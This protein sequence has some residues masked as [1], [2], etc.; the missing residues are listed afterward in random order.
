MEREWDYLIHL[1]R[2]AI[3]DIPPEEVPA[4][5]DLQRV[6]ECG[7]YH[8]VANLAF[9]SVER[10]KNPPSDELYN[11]WQSNRDKA[12]VLDFNQ[13]FAADEIRDAFGNENIQWLELQG[14][15]IKPLYPQPEYRTMSDI[16]FIVEKENLLRAGE[17]LESL[18]YSTQLIR[19]Q[20]IVAFREPNI[21]V[22][23]HS[24]YFENSIYNNAMR[25]P[26]K[27]EWDVETFYLYN[28]LHIAKHYRYGGC[29]IR[30]VLDAYMLN[31]AYGEN[32][33]PMQLLEK[34]EDREFAAELLEL[35]NAWFGEGKS[36]RSQMA[37][38]IL[39][40]GTHGNQYNELQNRLDNQPELGIKY[41]LRRIL[42]NK[43]AMHI[44]YPILERYKILYPFCWLHRGLC[45]MLPR[46][47]KRL[48]R[49][50]LAIRNHRSE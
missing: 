34:P 49:E 36:V 8:H 38:Y 10:L 40:S 26:I 33:D 50:F 30:R 4:D 21:N 39:Y 22:E 46:K 29:G 20:E 2:C 3:H 35:A 9:Y 1:I 23:I 45:A 24:Q 15:M 25:E 32:V 11:I 14:T 6:Y 19:N 47:Q 27:Y 16:D 28:I 17:I 42:G 48:K 18:G 5:V 13:S 7:A 37:H 31:R 43:Q 41:I 12:L 44:S